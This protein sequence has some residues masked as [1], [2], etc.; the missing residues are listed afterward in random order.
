MGWKARLG[1]DGRS[2]HRGSVGSSS[3]IAKSS[4]AEPNIDVVRA[5]TAGAANRPVD[6]AH[7]TDA[8]LAHRFDAPYISEGA[9][10]FEGLAAD[11]IIATYGGAPI[12]R[13]AVTYGHHAALVVDTWLFYA[14]HYNNGGWENQT[15]VLR[16]YGAADIV[17][18]CADGSPLWEFRC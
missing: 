6:V 15:T 9:E 16:G 10:T 13:L 14:V 17:G 1:M 4:W 5:A 7:I 8:F 2:S 18:S 3:T 12:G 11:A